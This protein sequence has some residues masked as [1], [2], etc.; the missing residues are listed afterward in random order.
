MI[1]I[2]KSSVSKQETQVNSAL[3]HINVTNIFFS[4]NLGTNLLSADPNTGAVTVVQDIDRESLSE[5]DLRLT[6]S[7]QD[8]PKGQLISE[9]PFDILNLPKKQ[10]KKLTNFSPRI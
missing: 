2:Q 9:C 4:S 7:V 10:R 3:G 1:L 8:E 5:N 6:V